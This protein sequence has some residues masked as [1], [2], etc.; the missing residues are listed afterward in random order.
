MY[1][2]NYIDRNAL[3]YARIQGI[4]E[5]LNMTGIVREAPFLHSELILVLFCTDL[6]V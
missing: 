3:P 5:D 4:E 2:N 6:S 1:L